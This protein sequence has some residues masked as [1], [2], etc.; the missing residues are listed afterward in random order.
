[1]GAGVCACRA[2][3]ARA[4]G[5]ARAHTRC[6]ITLGRTGCWGRGEREI[7]VV[8]TQ[9]LLLP[10]RTHHSYTTHTISL[11]GGGEGRAGERVRWVGE[12]E[13][14]VVVTQCL[15]LPTRPHHSYITH[16]VSLKGG[17]GGGCWGKGE[18]HDG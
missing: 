2:R 5:C 1:M 13:I 7:I 12:R 17:G 3:G 9:C 18:V 16:T 4:A 15:L 6:Q 10:T 14:L 8:V 11:V